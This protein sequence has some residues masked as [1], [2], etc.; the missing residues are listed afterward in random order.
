M[1]ESRWEAT[2]AFGLVGCVSLTVNNL[3]E[4]DPAFGSYFYAAFFFFVSAGNL[5]L[6][7]VVRRLGLRGTIILG[8]CFAG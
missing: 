8:C 3:T 5:L 7:C 1:C 6:S 2:K 4:D